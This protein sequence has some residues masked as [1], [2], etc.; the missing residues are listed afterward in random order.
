MTTFAKEAEFE[1]AALLTNCVTAGVTIERDGIMN[2]RAAGA[3]IEVR[4]EKLLN[5]HNHSQ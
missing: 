2:Y 1:A 5:T 4:A 3:A